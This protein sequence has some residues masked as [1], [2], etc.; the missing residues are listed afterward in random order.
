MVIRQSVNSLLIRL[1]D[2][3]DLTKFYSAMKDEA[4]GKGK[5][6]E[7]IDKY[8]KT[9]RAKDEWTLSLSPEG[10]RAKRSYIK[11]ENYN[12]GVML[13][14][15]LLAAN[16]FDEKKTAIEMLT[17][18]NED[19][20]AHIF[21]SIRENENKLEESIHS[22]YNIN[23]SF[24]DQIFRSRKAAEIKRMEMIQDMLEAMRSATE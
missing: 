7:E 16:G 6:F 12:T 21:S 9:Q 20:I 19:L 13:S 15:I 24:S 2:V 4:Q 1:R 18:S 10:F 8:L 22:I 23:K 14:M 11:T 5:K 17:R 3:R